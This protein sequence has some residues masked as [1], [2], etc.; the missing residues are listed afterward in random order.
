MA[1]YIKVNAA[2]WQLSGQLVTDKVNAVLE[3]SNALSLPKTGWTLDFANVW[4][5]DSAAVSLLLAWLRRGK[6]EQVPLQ[7]IN[8]PLN[9]ITLVKLYGLEEVVRT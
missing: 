3:E 4:A 8:L 7:F 9:L 6:A 5:V 2:V 1:S